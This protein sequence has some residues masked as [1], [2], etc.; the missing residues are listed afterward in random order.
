M[1]SE[2]IVGDAAVRVEPEVQ[3]I[4]GRYDVPGAIRQRLATEPTDHLVASVSTVVDLQEIVFAVLG[5]FD[6]EFGK[7]DV[8]NEQVVGGEKPGAAHI[9]L[10]NEPIVGEN[11]LSSLIPRHT[12]ARLSRDFAFGA[13]VR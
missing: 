10:I 1:E 5:I 12:A 11:E 4:V 6:I 2:P 7:G 8:Q 13:G 9:V 3:G